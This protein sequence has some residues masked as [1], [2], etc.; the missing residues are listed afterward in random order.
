M[1]GNPVP[2]DI[3][4]TK[5]EEGRGACSL[6]EGWSVPVLVAISI[7][8]EEKNPKGG[9]CLV[10]KLEELGTMGSVINYLILLK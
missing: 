6:P 8:P 2:K 10:G 5:E 7:Y 3:P 1:A 9:N 4:D